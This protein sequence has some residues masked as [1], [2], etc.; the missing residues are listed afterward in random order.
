[1]ARKNEDGDGQFLCKVQ[2]LK[3]ADRFPSNV[4]IL[5]LLDAQRSRREKKL[6]VVECHNSPNTSVTNNLYQCLID[7]VSVSA[8][9][10]VCL[11]VCLVWRALVFCFVVYE[12][13]TASVSKDGTD[14][15]KTFLKG[16]RVC[17]KTR[18]RG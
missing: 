2:V 17:L 9:E 10:Q 16:K 13:F 1:M 18:Y 12:I 15:G 7:K 8:L 11:F 4:S 6:T 5:K 14:C 3:L